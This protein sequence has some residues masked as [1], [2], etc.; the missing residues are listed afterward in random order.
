MYRPNKKVWVKIKRGHCKVVSSG[1]ADC[2]HCPTE[3]MK[4]NRSFE[5]GADA[6]LGILRKDGSE[7]FIQRT[8]GSQYVSMTYFYSGNA[9][10]GRLVFIPEEK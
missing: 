10:K 6:M 7:Q 5:A 4:C 3:P 2:I 8:M 9:E 1:K